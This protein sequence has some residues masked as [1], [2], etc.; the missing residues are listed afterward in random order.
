MHFEVDSP[1][2]CSSFAYSFSSIITIR[3]ISIDFRT[4]FAT[5]LQHFT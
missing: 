2:Y 5:K 3:G 4:A 1:D